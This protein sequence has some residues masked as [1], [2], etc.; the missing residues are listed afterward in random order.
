MR[1]GEARIIEAEVQIIEF[2]SKMMKPCLEEEVEEAEVLN[3]HLKQIPTE[4]ELN[5]IKSKEMISI[6]EVV[7]ASE[8]EEYLWK[9]IIREI[10]GRIIELDTLTTE[11]F[12][13]ILK[14]MSKA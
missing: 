9:M 12:Y 2:L 13:S 3:N 4:V 8:V 7:E 1:E 5:I 10:K 14:W 6:K 11:T